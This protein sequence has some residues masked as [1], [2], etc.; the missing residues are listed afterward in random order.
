MIPKAM[1]LIVSVLALLF[2]TAFCF[3]Q[4]KRANPQ[5]PKRD[6]AAKPPVKADAAP[7]ATADADE[8]DDSPD[9][10]PIARGRIDPGTYLRLRDE[11]VALKRGLADLARDPQAR[12]H[13]IRHMELQEQQ[14][15]RRF[16]ARSAQ[17]ISGTGPSSTVVPTP[18]WTPLG[19]DPIPNGQTSPSEVPVSGR[20]LA[21]AIDPTNENI[22]YVGAAQGGLYRT[23]DGG[24]TWTAL[25]DSAQ[26]LA[27]GAITIDPL[28]RNTLFVGTGEGNFCL[29]CFFGVGLYIIRNATTTAV[30]SGPFNSNGTSDVITGRAIT[31]ILV[32]PATD[33][34][35]L[36]S[37]ASGFSGASGDVFSTLPARGV[38]FSSNALGVTPTFTL[39]T[40]PWVGNRAVTDMAIDPNNANLVVV[41]VFGNAVAG[42]GGIWITTGGS[43]WSGVATWAQK[44]TKLAI[45][46]LAVNFSTTPP[47]TTPATTFFATFDETTPCVN[48]FRGTLFKSAD[49]GLT[50]T[51]VVP[52]RGFCRG[53]CFYDMVPA[54]KPDDVN[55]IL[56]GGSSNSGTPGNC[57]GRTLMKSTN[58]GTSFA[59]SDA[60]LHADSH[61][62]V[63][64]PSNVSVIYAGNDGGIFRSA[65][66]G[67]T[68]TSRNTAGFQ[69][70][71]F[72]S[73]S[74]HPLDAN[75]SIGGTQD[76]GTPRLLPDGVTWTRADFGDGGFSAID[77]NAPDT[78]NVTMYHT[79]FNQSNNLIGFAQTNSAATTEGL[80]NFFGCQGATSNNGM[81][82]ADNVLFYAPLVLGPGNPNTVYF[83]TD[84]LYRSA[85]QGASMTL[86]SQAP[87]GPGSPNVPV[88]AIGIS[89]QD[90]NVRI[91]G[92]K[93]GRA[94]ATST[95]STFLTDVTGGWA[96]LFIARAVI[97]PNDKNTAYVT[98]DG[99]GTPSHVW[100]TTNLS[101]APP[102]VPNWVAASTGLPDVPVNAFAVDP[103][104]SIA[105]YAG[106]DIGVYNS[107]DGGATWNP[108]GTGLPRVAVFDMNIQPTSRLL[109]VG[110]H[111]K[112]AWETTAVS[113]TV[114]TTGLLSSSNNPNF[115]ANVIFTASITPATG[116]IPTGTVTFKDGTTTL[117]TGTLNALAQATFQTSTLTVGTHNI[118]AFYAGDSTYANSTSSVV[119]VTV[120]SVTLPTTTTGSGNPTSPVFGS[121]VTL[122]AT[123]DKGSGTI[124]PTGTVTFKEG[125]NTLGMGTLN[126]SAQASFATSA[127]AGGAHNITATYGGDTNYTASTS[128]PFVVTVQ[129]FTLGAPSPASQTVNAGQSTSYTI[130]LTSVGGF[131]SSSGI[132]FTCSLAATATTCTASPNPQTTAGGMVTI[133]VTTMA[134][135]AVPLFRRP[136]PWL[137]YIILLM[138][139]G[140]LL[141]RMLR[142][143]S[144]RR[145]RIV[146]T[147]PLVALAL[148][149]IFHA[150][151][152]GGK[153]TPPP[154]TGTPAGAYPFTVTGTSGTA[155]HTTSNLTLNVN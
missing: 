152:C 28:D 74:V 90:D 36:V 130:S 37:T 3:A 12:S 86:V 17:A 55:T 146:L 13:A 101:V 30:L 137:P 67:A 114:S 23:M 129:D 4:E 63:F 109:R 95:G 56:L 7:A 113:F 21:I 111:G 70:T 140:W 47:A 76:N 10:P 66:G 75:F 39:S 110:T 68:W 51:E 143:N 136:G 150:V 26:S 57:G 149:I 25:M 11:L 153:S 82:C 27:I 145:R 123:V 54:I 52:A 127:L 72:E 108:Y 124:T 35:I 83:G 9:I 41:N 141:S 78:A 73:M 69:A 89:P 20:V 64:A 112:G 97:D 115:G 148:F 87:L 15:I 71:Q 88:S 31:Q 62:T 91:V 14:L 98:L 5:E 119:V 85:N 19:P 60:N 65:D 50:W 1:R 118:T 81:T 40:T 80:W 59:A 8:D 104:N 53:Q 33:N 128:A 125:A 29:D 42:D 103:V 106:T 77:Q 100:K 144:S 2:A 61:A 94:F 131:P 154:V 32:N 147:A 49:L 121:S 22:A 45:G 126:A 102:I 122:S 99:Y 48:G 135:G 58:G 24:G 16:Q 117:G 134:R 139:L 6:A 142:L 18:S 155:S 138:T 120:V 38:Y 151:G 93:N 105:L 133:N 84:R 46:K 44:I 92:L 116:P 132:N 107:L 34:Q 96:G 43:P 79:Y